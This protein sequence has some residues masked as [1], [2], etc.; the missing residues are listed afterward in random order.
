MLHAKSA[1]NIERTAQRTE[2]SFGQWLLSRYRTSID[3]QWPELAAEASPLKAY[4]LALSEIEQASLEGER[5]VK[6]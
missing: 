3:I 6:H 4:K 5:N 1:W 2:E